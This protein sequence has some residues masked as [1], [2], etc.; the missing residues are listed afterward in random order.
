MLEPPT[1]Q[2]ATTS[3]KIPRLIVDTRE[4]NPW[5][6]PSYEIVRC[7]LHTGDYC[8]EGMD[9]I[10]CIERKASVVEFAASLISPRFEKELQRMNHKYRYLILEFDFDDLIRYPDTVVS[11]KVRDR[12][13][14]TGKFLVKRFFELQIRYKFVPIFVG[15]HGI[16]AISSLFKR[17]LNETQA[18]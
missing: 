12:T 14:L 3:K 9:K 6:L 4:R 1:S 17:I 10:L 13:K 15:N 5:I 2:E 8:F 16:D 11:A 7:K 18:G